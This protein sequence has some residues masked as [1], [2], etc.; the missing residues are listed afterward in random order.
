MTWR[1]AADNYVV[2]AVFRGREPDAPRTWK[3]WVL[4]DEFRQVELVVNRRGYTVGIAVASGGV[5]VHAVDTPADDLVAGWAAER[6]DRRVM[7]AIRQV[8]NPLRPRRKSGFRGLLHCVSLA[9]AVLMLRG[10]WWIWTPEALWKHLLKEAHRGGEP[11][12]FLVRRN[13]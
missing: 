8:V 10:L 6:G 11:P 9:K 5:M 2:W 4:H 13:D 1:C 7:H 3:D 12:R